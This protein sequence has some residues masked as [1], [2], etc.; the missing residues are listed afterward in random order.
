MHFKSVIQ[1]RHSNLHNAFLFNLIFI[2]IYLD[3]GMYGSMADATLLIG[4]DCK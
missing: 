4:I 2:C 1:L 3:T